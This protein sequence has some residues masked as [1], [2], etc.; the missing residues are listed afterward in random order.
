LRGSLSLSLT[1]CGRP[2]VRASRV[3]QLIDTQYTGAITDRFGHESYAILVG[4]GWWVAAA[5]AVIFLKP[6]GGYHSNT[7][8]APLLTGGGGH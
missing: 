6:V 2:L 8:R 3:A 4:A 7:A 5:I 1:L